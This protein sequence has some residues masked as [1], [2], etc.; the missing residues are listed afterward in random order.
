MYRPNGRAHIK[1][2]FVLENSDDF[3]MKFRLHIL[4]F[5][6]NSHEAKS[7]NDEDF[8]TRTIW[9]VKETVARSENFSSWFVSCSSTKKL[10]FLQLLVFLFS[11]L[12]TLFS[13][14][15]SFR[16][17]LEFKRIFLCRRRTSSINYLVS[18]KLRRKSSG[19]CRRWD[20]W[21]KFHSFSILHQWDHLVFFTTMEKDLL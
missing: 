15:F 4:I 20:V 10:I 21:I 17:S 13:F 3:I 1:D 6:T 9:N 14:S 12:T 19:R 18:G 5:V 16:D 2:D 7:N 8:L 11:S